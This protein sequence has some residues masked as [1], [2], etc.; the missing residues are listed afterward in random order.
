VNQLTHGHRYIDCT[1][2]QAPPK[3]AHFAV[4]LPLPLALTSI[5]NFHFQ[6]PGRD[7]RSFLLSTALSRKVFALSIRFASFAR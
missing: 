3:I 6:F 7:A 4:G 2:N 5:R 1:K